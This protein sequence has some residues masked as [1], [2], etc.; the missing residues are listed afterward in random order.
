[1]PEPSEFERLVA[2][3]RAGDPTAVTEVT[4][5]Y[6]AYLRATVRR[7]LHPS[8][9]TRYDSLDMVQDVWASF[10]ALAP[11]R[12]NFTDP[13]SLLAFLEQVAYHRTVEVFRHRFGTQK[14][15]IARETPGETDAT[16]VATTPTPSMFVAAADEWDAM[17]RQFPPGHRV[18]LQRLKEG[19]DNA[20]IARMANVS[21]ST[22]N[23]VVRR[24]KDIAGE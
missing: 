19:Y 1:V 14:D 3:L 23:R 16:A 17:V 13:N 10:L 12:L 7:R 15:D 22:V 24:L 8:L 4:R 18:I 6:G 11:E 20:E 2:G 9:R 5:R 21:L